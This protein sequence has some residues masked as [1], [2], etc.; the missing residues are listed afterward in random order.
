[1]KERQRSNTRKKKSKGKGKS[2]RYSS[3]D[4]EGLEKIKKGSK[5]GKW[6]SSD[7]N[8]SLSTESEFSQDTKKGKKKAKKKSDDYCS[9]DSRERS[10]RRSR[11]KSVRK[12]YESEEG[13]SSASD[14]S[15]SLFGGQARPKKS[16]RKDV[17]EKKKIKGERAN[18]AVNSVSENEIARKE[19]GLD[20]MLRT[21]NKRPA[22][23][24]EKLPEEALVEE[25]CMTKK[26][27][28]CIYCQ[29][30]NTDFSNQ[31]LFVSIVHL[32]CFDLFWL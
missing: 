19:M 31:I 4:D 11:S 12:E 15:D 23:E 7:E 27:N 5:K 17:D 14:D 25:V 32:V 24:M 10:K 9:D 20:W 6:Y 22:E 13:F 26:K 30:S 1:M 29:I 8:S 3:S 16:M 21:E 28:I 2:S 18:I